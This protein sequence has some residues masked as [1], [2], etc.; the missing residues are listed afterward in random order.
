MKKIKLN[1][2]KKSTILLGIYF[3]LVLFTTA[4]LNM[5]TI[6]T[7]AIICITSFIT[8]VIERK[9]KCSIQ[10]Y[11]FSFLVFIIFI[12]AFSVFINDYLPTDL[13]LKLL[14]FYVMYL[15]ATSHKYNDSEVS[16][17]TS[18]IIFSTTSY[19]LY[20]I[21]YGVNDGSHLFRRTLIILG[22]ELDP[23]YLSAAFVFSSVLLIV[24]ILKKRATLLSIFMYGILLYATVLTASRGALVSLVIS[25]ILAIAIWLTSENES[26][27][28]KYNKAFHLIFLLIIIL[29]S[30]EVMQTL[31]VDNVSRVTNLFG[32]DGN[33]R[34]DIWKEAISLFKYRPAFGYGIDSAYR[35]YIG[36]ACHNTFVKL[37]FETG[38]FGMILF[39]IPIFALLKKVNK[40]NAIIIPLLLSSLLPLFFLDGID[41]KLLWNALI[42][43]EILADNEDDNTIN[44]L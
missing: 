3:S 39:F 18:F 25:N 36:M 34:I 40:H 43:C 30:W 12:T 16:A 27:K 13:L 29:V 5:G 9:S 15:L 2:H 35:I 11:K 26:T 23:N 37:L 6:S 21:L 38:L 22:S 17:L 14:C 20:F 41:S 44:I 31:L 24:R 33:G 10:L 42:F 4:Y 1:L 28:Q 8:V 32:D 19:A 7:V